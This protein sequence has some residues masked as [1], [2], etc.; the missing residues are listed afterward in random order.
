MKTD[1]HSLKTVLTTGHLNFSKAVISLFFS[2]AI[3]KQLNAVP[4]LGGMQGS[5]AHYNG[6]KACCVKHLFHDNV[7]WSENLAEN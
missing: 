1:Q 5:L 7:I 4:Y 2:V 3:S 6:K